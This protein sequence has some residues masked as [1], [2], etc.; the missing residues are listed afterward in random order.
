MIIV[1]Y[2]KLKFQNNFNVFNRNFLCEFFWAKS[3]KVF[4]QIGRNIGFEKVN[5]KLARKMNF[6]TL[7]FVVGQSKLTFCV[8]H[9]CNYKKI[10]IEK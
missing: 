2:C 3:A 6:C 10:A 5:E 8:N 9:S 4:D 1:D 7:I